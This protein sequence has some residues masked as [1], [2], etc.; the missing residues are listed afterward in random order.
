MTHQGREIVIGL[1]IISMF[2]MAYL[3]VVYAAALILDILGLEVLADLP[4]AV[5]T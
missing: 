4:G 2:I 5:M 1:V 3:L